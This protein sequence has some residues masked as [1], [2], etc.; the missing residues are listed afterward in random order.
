MPKETISQRLKTF[1]K[2]VKE[3][4]SH[5]RGKMS[6]ETSGVAE[7]RIA[8]GILLPYLDIE[9]NTELAEDTRI[10]S[11][12]RLD[13]Q[14]VILTPDNPDFAK[15][16][17]LKV[18]NK[19]LEREIHL[20]ERTMEMLR[21]FPDIME[22]NN[23]NGVAAPVEYE[24]ASRL[25]VLIND[26]FPAAQSFAATKCPSWSFPDSAVNE[27]LCH[28]HIT[29]PSHSNSAV[30]GFHKSSN[31][32]NFQLHSPLNITDIGTAFFDLE[33]EYEIKFLQIAYNVFKAVNQHEQALN[34]SFKTIAIESSE[35]NLEKLVETPLTNNFSDTLTE[36]NQ[37]QIV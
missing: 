34:A 28:L 1:A 23:E 29:R 37:S 24:L 2:R 33:L 3:L 6:E 27:S 31:R 30:S 19:Y 14:S 9:N 7:V 4:P 11:R 22:E 13:Q 8:S 21:N 20:M 25:S 36:L 18:A 10:Q 12:K 17:R 5:L 32:L 35:T 16:T 26:L 15:A